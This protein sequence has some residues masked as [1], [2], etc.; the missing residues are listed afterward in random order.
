MGERATAAGGGQEEAGDGESETE[1]RDRDHQ[2]GD[3]PL[4]VVLAA[5]S[6]FSSVVVCIPVLLMV[7]VDF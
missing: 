4:H 1:G 2:E 6:C 7:V 3:P 5:A